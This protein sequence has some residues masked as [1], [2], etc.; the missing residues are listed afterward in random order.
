MRGEPG[1]KGRL[2]NMSL[3]NEGGGACKGVTQNLSKKE[4]G[5]YNV[6]SGLSNR[7][8]KKK[9]RWETDGDP[10]RRLTGRGGDVCNITAR[11]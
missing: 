11:D 9:G 2:P 5:A 1:G 7:G 3:Q 8:Q 6:F 10:K 4:E